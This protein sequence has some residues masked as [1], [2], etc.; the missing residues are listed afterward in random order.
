MKI[1]YKNWNKTS[2]YNLNLN[3]NTI[4]IWQFIKG[5]INLILKSFVQNKNII[6]NNYNK[7]FL[8]FLFNPIYYHNLSLITF[9]VSINKLYTLVYQ[10]VE[11]S[12]TV[13]QNTQDHHKI[14]LHS[15]V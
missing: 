11:E 3:L 6:L 7:L 8:V 12:C 5:G 10:F 4:I 14:I 13:L 15:F 9:K 1:K 2:T